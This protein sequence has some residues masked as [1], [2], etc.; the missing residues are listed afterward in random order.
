MARSDIDHSLLFFPDRREFLK[1][2]IAI[3][4][5]SAFFGSAPLLL[6]A[7]ATSSIAT[8]IGTS[9]ASAFGK[10]VGTLAFGSIV[11]AIGIDTDSSSA[12]SAAILNQLNQISTQLTALASEVQSIRTEIEVGFAEQ[13]YTNAVG[14]VLG[15]ITQTKHMTD[16]FSD[17]VA[18]IPAS[19]DTPEEKSYKRQRILDMKAHINQLFA[20]D[21]YFGGLDTWNAVMTGIADSNLS[22]IKTWSK[23]VYVKANA[24][25]GVRQARKVQKLWD[26]Y[27]AQ[28]ALMASYLIDYYHATGLYVTAR[29]TLSNWYRNRAQQLALLR[30]Q[31]VSEDRFQMNDGN[32]VVTTKVTPLNNAL[33]Q[34]VIILKPANNVLT[35]Y[36]ASM[37]CLKLVRY[38]N[39]DGVILGMAGLIANTI[40]DT[41]TSVYAKRTFQTGWALPTNAAIVMLGNTIG[42]DIV[43]S[44]DHVNHFQDALL[45]AGFSFVNPNGSALPNPISLLSGQGTF[46]QAQ[47]PYRAGVYND[48]YIE[49]QAWLHNPDFPRKRYFAT[50][51]FVL[52]VRG[53]FPKSQGEYYWWG[54]DS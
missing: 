18:L 5:G 20:Q 36:A 12:Q 42:A 29:T 54:F 9:V 52:F 32:G 46:E 53:T 41:K 16:S 6:E 49:G 7:Q 22:L 45:Q 33:P 38:G 48:I 3:A 28:Q 25:Y 8:Q 26:Y 44:D 23:L 19:T 47:P 27:D 31:V 11:S 21:G 40:A 1:T 35:D 30:G 24:W 17:L 43:A 4:A 10:Q 39:P 51:P 14:L 50:I 2:S 34:N 15:L 37:W 13:A